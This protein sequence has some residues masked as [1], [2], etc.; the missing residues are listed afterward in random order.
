MHAKDKL[1]VSHRNVGGRLQ[2][3][4]THARLYY[5]SSSSELYPSYTDGTM[6]LARV[7]KGAGQATSYIVPRDVGQRP[8]PDRPLAPPPL[9]MAAL[10]E[11]VGGK[12]T[13][14]HT[15]NNDNN[16]QEG[17]LTHYYEHQSY[18]KTPVSSTPSRGFTRCVDVQR[19]C[20]TLPATQ[21]LD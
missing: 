4:R 13:L 7:G 9:S 19:V 5:L 2:L 20:Q 21:R 14:L 17:T 16:N 6:N 18:W 1:W 12:P 15:V 10:G 11:S 3:N 8:T